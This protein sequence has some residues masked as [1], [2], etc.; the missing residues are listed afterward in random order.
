MKKALFL[1]LFVLLSA[2]LFSQ[3]Y[4]S[5][6]GLRFGS[7][8]AASYKTFVG[9]SSAFE[10]IVGLGRFNSNV[11]FFDIRAAYLIHEDI[12]SAEN[13]RWYYGGGAG[14]FFWS[15]K[16]SFIGERDSSTGIALSGYVGIEYTLPDTPIS[17]SIDWAPTFILGGGF[18]GGFGAGYGGLSVRY[19]LQR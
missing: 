6:V 10:G 2:S 5:A 11:N 1:S 7:P 16:D 3:D 9:E 15:F 12:D 13:L 18:F 17:A 14:L 19:V 4:Q 8:T